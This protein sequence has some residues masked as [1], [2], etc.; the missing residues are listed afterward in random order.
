MPEELS[1]L[2]SNS[3]RNNFDVEG[4]SPSKF[5][6]SNFT[7]SSTKSFKKIRDRHKNIDDKK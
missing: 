7:V 1:E 6:G 2:Y 5:N 4:V 3:S